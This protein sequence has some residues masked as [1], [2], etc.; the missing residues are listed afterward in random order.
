MSERIT[1]ETK[2]Y[3]LGTFVLKLEHHEIEGA[4][5]NKPTIQ[6]AALH[7][8][9]DWRLAQDTREEA[10][11]SL[12]RALSKTDGFQN[13]ASQLEE[14]AEDTSAATKQPLI[15]IGMQSVLKASFV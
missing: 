5:T 4:E 6:G 9:H 13:L 11:D 7:I 3:R 15:S 12:Y 2:L 1:T 14:W 8:L 10:F